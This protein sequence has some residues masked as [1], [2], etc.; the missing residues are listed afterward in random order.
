MVMIGAVALVAVAGVAAVIVA[1]GLAVVTVML[2]VAAGSVLCPCCADLVVGHNG[3]C[4]LGSGYGCLLVAKHTPGG[5]V[6]AG[7]GRRAGFT[8]SLPTR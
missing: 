5:Y 1:I 7:L 8:L 6:P 4:L 2:V 3:R